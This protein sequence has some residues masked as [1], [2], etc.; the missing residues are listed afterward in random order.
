MQGLVSS[1]LLLIVA[2]ISYSIGFLLLTIT[3]NKTVVQCELGS[4]TAH[5][6]H[7]TRRKAVNSGKAIFLNS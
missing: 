6:L 7:H 3:K 1:S 2:Y 4:E 5:I